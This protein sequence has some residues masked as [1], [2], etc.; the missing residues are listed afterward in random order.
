VKRNER[1]S[2]SQAKDDRILKPAKA[3]AAVQRDAKEV[4]AE[5]LAKLTE[6][7][8]PKPAQ[9]STTGAKQHDVRAPN[10]DRLT[11]GVDLGD[12]WSNYCILGLEGETLSEGQLR[13]TRQNFAEFFEALS[14]ARV[15]IEVGT[16]SAWVREVVA[17]FGH[18][19]LV[20]NPR[21]MDGGRNRKRKND[22]IDA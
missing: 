2:N 5:L 6:R 11:V 9:E 17:C 19:L 8:E 20:A 7:L 18:E 14:A 22:R 15:V 16:H 3:R 1:N 10:R 4:M 12:K 21:L 13:T